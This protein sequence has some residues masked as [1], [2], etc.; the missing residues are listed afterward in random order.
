MQEALQGDKGQHEAALHDL[1]G[2]VAMYADN[3][4]YRS[5]YAFALTAD[6]QREAALQQA[7]ILD[8]SQVDTSSFHFN[9]EQIFWIP[10]NA[11]K[12][13]QHLQLAFD[14]AADDEE[15]QDVVAR[16]R[17]PL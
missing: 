7:A 3:P 13:R 8:K 10:G 17:A 6:G 1:A 11:T 12:G 2:L 16:I 14:Y 4:F 15:R 5:N 9:L